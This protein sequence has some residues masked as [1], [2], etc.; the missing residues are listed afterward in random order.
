[1][2]V[3]LDIRPLRESPSF[4]RMWAGSAVSALGITMTNFAVTL[5][6]Y[7]LT[8]SAFAVGAVG[9]ARIIPVLAVALLGASL[10]DRFDRRRV[11]LCTTSAAALVA[12][13]LAA[14]ALAG[15]RLVWLLYVL[16]AAQSAVMSVDA[17]ARRT[18]TPRLLPAS[19]LPAGLALSYLVIPGSVLLGPPLAGLLATAGGLRLCYVA[20]L[21]SYAA[22][23]YAAGRLPP[24]PPAPVP[25]APVP[26]APVPHVT[27]GPP[28]AAPGRREQ[29]VAA[30]I[31]FIMRSRAVAGAFIADLNANVLGLP[32]ALFPAINAERF[33]GSPATLGLLTGAVGAGGLL[34]LAFSGP[35]GHVT[36]T[37]R[38]MLATVALWGAAVA[39][40]GL[41]RG[42]G[43]ALACLVLA[44]MAS[45]AV[46]V[47][48]GIIVQTAIPEHLRGRITAADF[49]VGFGGDQL[50]SLESGAVGSLFTPTVSAVSGGLGTIAGA[51]ITGLALPAFTRY[52]QPVQPA[53]QR[54]PPSLPARVDVRPAP[55]V[56]AS[57]AGSARISTTPRAR[58]SA[59]TSA[60]TCPAAPGPPPAPPCLGPSDLG[61]S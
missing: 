55:R 26:P 25:P 47:L 49:V 21:V 46:S 14:Q 38:A 19:L 56:D 16:A 36:R 5:Q 20:D 7:R 37:G 54:Q 2:R 3:L 24:V 42:L 12:A 11:V 43:L 53:A 34:G 33:G 39:G 58:P 8:H 18:L 29:S 9:L 52:R 17:P 44:G 30:S 32:T 13:L 59:P 35:V 4:R 10:A 41:A 31:R 57:P 27:A 60:E 22:V 23:L 40:F 50:G 28:G 15:L 51:I 6:V 48:R 45:S 61:P 1:M